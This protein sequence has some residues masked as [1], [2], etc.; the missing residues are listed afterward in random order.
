MLVSELRLLLQ[1][2]ADPNVQ[3][4]SGFPRG[5]TPLHEL[6]DKGYAS[7]ELDPGVL[8]AIAELFVQHGARSIR[9][10]E[11]RTA[12][13]RARAWAQRLPHYQSVADLLRAG[14]AA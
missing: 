9:N 4:P 7:H 1:A 5:N 3:N 2:G 8:V 11:G 10:A 6:L 12:A 14:T 13:D